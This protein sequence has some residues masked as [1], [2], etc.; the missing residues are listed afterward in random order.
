MFEIT[1]FSSFN[2]FVDL[3]DFLVDNNKL[4]QYIHKKIIVD[5]KE[6]STLKADGLQAL[7]DQK[8]EEV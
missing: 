7:R 5:N 6:A 4:Q 8:V 3:Q 2:E 1:P